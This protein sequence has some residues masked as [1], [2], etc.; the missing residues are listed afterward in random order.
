M[1]FL[2]LTAFIVSGTT[3][4][5]AQNPVADGND[6][7]GFDQSGASLTEVQNYG[8]KMYIDND[9]GGINITVTCAGTGPLF[10]CITD[11]PVLPVGTHTIQLTASNFAGESAKS[12]PFV[13]DSVIT[14]APPVSMRIIRR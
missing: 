8:Y 10:Q 4:V 7:L 1:K 5:Y 2:V 12:L 11:L 9:V 3:L 13:F 6:Q 14:P